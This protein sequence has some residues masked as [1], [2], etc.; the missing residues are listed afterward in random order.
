MNSQKITLIGMFI[1]LALLATYIEHLLPPLI[2]A[3]P[4]FKLGLANIVILCLLY[5]FNGKTSLCVN[6]LRILLAGFLFAGF[7]SILYAFAGGILSFIAMYFAKKCS[8]FSILGVSV[9]GATLHN[10][11][12]ICVAI[13]IL[14]SKKLLYYLPMLTISAVIT[15]LLVG[16]VAFYLVQHLNVY[17][18]KFV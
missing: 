12:Q 13:M 10:V 16:L 15:G 6:L 3:V 5:L 9:L 2:P 7:S 4:G 11:G 8:A 14:Q 18:K 1:T 17:C